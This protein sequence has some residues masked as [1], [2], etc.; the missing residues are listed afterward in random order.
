MEE[1]KDG[2]PI[3]I[4]IGIIGGNVE[5]LAEIPLRREKDGRMERWNPD[6]DSYRDY[7]GEGWKDGIQVVC[8]VELCAMRSAICDLNTKNGLIIL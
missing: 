5:A 4:A 3:P 1:W 8:A 7:R 6:P 2:T